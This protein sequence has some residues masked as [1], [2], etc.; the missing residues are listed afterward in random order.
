[1]IIN[2]SK[3]HDALHCVIKPLSFAKLIAA[4]KNEFGFESHPP[5]KQLFLSA[6]N[7]IYSPTKTNALGTL[8]DS[9]F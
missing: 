8:Q 2:R 6:F 3:K 5:P 1:M 4:V 9:I 7:K